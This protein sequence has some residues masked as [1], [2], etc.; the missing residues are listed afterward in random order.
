MVNGRWRSTIYGEYHGFWLSWTIRELALTSI[1]DVLT[2]KKIVALQTRIHPKNIA[3]LRFMILTPKKFEF[4]RYTGYHEYRY[5][6]I[7]QGHPVQQLLLQQPSSSSQCG[8]FLHYAIVVCT[9]PR[10]FA[11]LSTGR[12]GTRDERLQGVLIRRVLYRLFDGWESLYYYITF[13]NL[14]RGRFAGH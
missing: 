13:L 10:R 12:K 4:S 3:P 14:K 8:F 2:I 5:C 9:F 11:L 7:V 1:Y 6:R